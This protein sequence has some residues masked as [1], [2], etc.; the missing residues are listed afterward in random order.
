MFILQINS[1]SMVEFGTKER[2]IQIF[3]KADSAAF[4]NDDEV[5]TCRIAE[6]KNDQT[7]SEIWLN[8][9][10]SSIDVDV[11]GEPNEMMKEVGDV[12]R[13]KM[14]VNLILE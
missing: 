9:V 14:N 12:I 1:G 6:I 2:A 11:T 5:Y 7:I 13:T 10:G 8:N 4:R 3:K